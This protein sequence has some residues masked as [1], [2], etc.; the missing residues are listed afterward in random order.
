M[1]TNNPNNPIDA[2]RGANLHIFHYPAK[3]GQ[4]ENYSVIFNY[5]CNRITTNNQWDAVR[6]VLTDEFQRR[7]LNGVYGLGP[8]DPDR[9][10]ALYPD[11]SE[12]PNSYAYTL[13]CSREQLVQIQELFGRQQLSIEDG[14]NFPGM[15]SIS[16]EATECAV[17][18][19]S[20]PPSTPGKSGNLLG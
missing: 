15:K 11:G 10:R 14:R 12:R 1:T 16:F 13:S 3:N 19:S 6:D 17:A 2:L 4:P 8:G 5:P 9:I 7:G 20:P 18:F